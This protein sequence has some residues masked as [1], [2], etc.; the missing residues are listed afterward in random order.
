MGIESSRVKYFDR[1]FVSS[2][3]CKSYTIEESNFFS[4]PMVADKIPYMNLLSLLGVSSNN[5][6]SVLIRFNSNED[7]QIVYLEDG[8]KKEKTIRGEFVNEKYFE[9]F[10]NNE[11]LEIPPFFHVLYSRHH[12]DRVRL[13][14]TIEGNLIADWL[15]VQNGNILFFSAGSSSR[16]QGFFKC[17]AMR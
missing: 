2:F 17:T 11:T 10:H 5:A 7:L 1:N 14:L 4:S 13:A 9:V 15:Y 3:Y 8:K 16:A 6:D 12:V